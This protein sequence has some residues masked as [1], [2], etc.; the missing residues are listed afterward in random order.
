MPPRR[1]PG[2]PLPPPSPG[3]SRPEPPRRPAPRLAPD[4]ATLLP[5]PLKTKRSRHGQRGPTGASPPAI[6]DGGPL[7]FPP[8]RPLTPLPMSPGVRNTR[9]AARSGAQRRH[10]AQQVPNNSRARRSAFLLLACPARAPR[11]RSSDTAPA[12]RRIK[13]RPP[14]PVPPVARPSKRTVGAGGGA[15]L[16]TCK[17]GLTSAAPTAP[18]R[19]GLGAPP[20]TPSGLGVKPP[21]GAALP[22]SRPA[23]A[24]AAAMSRR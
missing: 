8:V 14:R 12:S 24:A 16:P 4:M 10:V 13:S 2:P 15:G 22:R 20:R 18:H 1:P 17:V 7:S 6:P 23:G 3:R 19:G 11:R 5:A 9:L 21:E